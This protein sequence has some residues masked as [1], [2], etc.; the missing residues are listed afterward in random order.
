MWCE[1][2]LRDSLLEEN[3]ISSCGW[4][5]IARNYGNRKSTP[6]EYQFMQEGKTVRGAGLP[7][8]LPRKRRAEISEK[9]QPPRNMTRMMRWAS[10]FALKSAPLLPG[11]RQK[12]FSIH[13]V[14]A[15]LL[16]LSKQVTRLQLIPQDVYWLCSNLVTVSLC[17]HAA[18]QKSDLSNL[19]LAP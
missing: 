5:V 16:V 13:L 14:E 11:E 9:V 7:L 18:G 2:F 15:A 1:M 8:S 12:A 10:F 4:E 6:Y 19:I 17:I 3:S